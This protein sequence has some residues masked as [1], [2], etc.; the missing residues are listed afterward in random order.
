[1][2]LSNI[3]PSRVKKF[4]KKKGFNLVNVKGSHFYYRKDEHLVGVV[5]HNNKELGFESMSGI[6]RQSGISKRIWMQEL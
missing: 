2:K 5:D 4:L 3:K 6:I 1:M